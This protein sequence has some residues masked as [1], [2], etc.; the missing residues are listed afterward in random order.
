MA[1]VTVKG[2]TPEGF[3]TRNLSVH[4]TTDYDTVYITVEQPT[5]KVFAGVNLDRAAALQLIA[6]LQGHYS[7]PPDSVG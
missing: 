6:F 3:K 5:G 4:A 2:T 1:L 7:I